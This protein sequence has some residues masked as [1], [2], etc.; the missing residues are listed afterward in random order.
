M[1]DRVAV[2]RARTAKLRPLD[3]RRQ[4]IESY[5]VEIPH[6]AQQSDQRI[7]AAE[8]AWRGEYGRRWVELEDARR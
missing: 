7:E 3:P 5:L 6:F 4:V 2:L 1:N 8:A